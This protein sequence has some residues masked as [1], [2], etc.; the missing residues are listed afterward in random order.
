MD[1]APSP[2][3]EELR[4]RL[5]AFIEDVVDPATPVAHRQVEES[6]D[7]HFHPPV[8]EELKA[9]AQGARPVEPVPARTRATAPG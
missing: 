6:G 7:P 5:E 4:S 1:F 2:R 8:M 9:E 3:A